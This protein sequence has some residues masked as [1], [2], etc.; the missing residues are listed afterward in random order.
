MMSLREGEAS[1][2]PLR[3]IDS[4]GGWL[5]RVERPGQKRPVALETSPSAASV[6]LRVALLYDMDACYAP[7]GVTRHALAQLDRLARRPEIALSVLTGR[8]RHPDGLAFWESLD[9]P[10]RR[11]LPPRTRDLLRWW[12]VKPWPPIEW[13]N[14]PIDW[15]HRP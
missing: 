13:R 3:D 9:L 10:A 6:A 5:S 1:S 12:R 14:G 7:T 8:M 2:E 4:R 11:E 15:V